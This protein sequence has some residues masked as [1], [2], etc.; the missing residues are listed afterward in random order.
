M[1]ITLTRHTTEGTHATTSLGFLALAG[2]AFPS[3]QAQAC[4]SA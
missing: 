2:I 1:A 3:I 4:I